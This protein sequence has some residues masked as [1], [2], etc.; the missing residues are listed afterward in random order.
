MVHCVYSVSQETAKHR[1]KFGRLPLSD[2]A[3][4]TKPR[5]E[6]G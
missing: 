1:A 3:A 2:V 5:V 4:V 6:T